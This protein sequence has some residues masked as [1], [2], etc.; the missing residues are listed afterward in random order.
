MVQTRYLCS[1]WSVSYGISR[2]RRC[3]CDGHTILHQNIHAGSEEEV[4]VEYDQPKGQRQDIVTR[5]DFE[6][7]AYGQLEAQVSQASS[8]A[9][10]RIMHRAARQ[11][12]K[13]GRCRYM[14]MC[15]G[16]RVL[17]TPTALSNCTP[18]AYACRAATTGHRDKQKASPTWDWQPVRAKDGGGG[19]AP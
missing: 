14:Y 10:P 9:F 11:G 13:D 1:A 18:H 7:L 4:V 16:P 5:S 3:A 12:R 6:E 19:G 8:T 2:R 17:V 15:P